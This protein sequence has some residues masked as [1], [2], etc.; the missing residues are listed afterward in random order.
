M[1]QAIM[2]VNFTPDMVAPIVGNY[3]KGWRVELREDGTLWAV[4]PNVQEYQLVLLPDGSY[5]VSNN[6]FFGIPVNFSVSSNGTVMAITMMMATT[7]TVTT[8]M[9]FKFD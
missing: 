4:L 7:G 3:E 8:E 5:M 9:L 1:L 2:Q 6:G